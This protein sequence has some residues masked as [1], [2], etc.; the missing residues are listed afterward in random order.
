MTWLGALWCLACALLYPTAKE[1]FTRGVSCDV[2]GAHF[3]K[4]YWKGRAAV[5]ES[6]ANASAVLSTPEMGADVGPGNRNIDVAFLVGST[7]EHVVLHTSGTQGVEAFPSSAIQAKFLQDGA[8]GA[9]KPGPSVL[10]VHALNPFGF[11]QLR[12]WN[13]DFID[14]NRNLLPKAGFGEAAKKDHATFDELSAFINPPGISKAGSFWPK[15]AFYIAT[16]GMAALKAAFISGQSPAKRGTAVTSCAL[17]EGEGV[18]AG[19]AGAGESL[20]EGAEGTRVERQRGEG[21]RG[22]LAHGKDAPF[23]EGAEGARVELRREAAALGGRLDVV[24]NLFGEGVEGT[25]ADGADNWF[26]EGAEGT[27]ADL[28]GEGAECTNADGAENWFGEGAEGASAEPRQE[29]VVLGRHAHVADAPFGKGAEG[30]HA[31]VELT[32]QRR[33]LADARAAQAEA[34]QDRW[35]VVG[36]P[37]PSSH[38]RKKARQREQAACIAAEAARVSRLQPARVAAAREATAGAQISA[39]ATKA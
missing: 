4:D 23:G 6:A 14:L 16:R 19:G 34:A 24:E 27:S 3:P 5:R 26:G 1:Q 13:E 32:R 18:R 20:G 7:P 2:V 10:R 36:Q 28:L 35:H 38:A 11:E 37:R 31:A 12:W 22:S 9:T 25:N 33:L 15:A 30:A 8:S 21:A 17:V 39:P 29:A